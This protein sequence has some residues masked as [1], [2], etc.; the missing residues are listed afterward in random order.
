MSSAAPLLPGLEEAMSGAVTIA[1]VVKKVR[2]GRGDFLVLE[3]EVERGG[4]HVIE[5]WVGEVPPT[6]PGQPVRGTGSYQ[7]HTS[8]GRQFKL[9]LLVP[10]IPSTRAGIIE[11][12]G[13]GQIEGIGPVYARAIVAHFGDGVLDVLDTDP[14]RVQEVPGI[15]PERSA[16]IVRGWRLSQA[17]ARVM[18]YLQGHGAPPGIAA[19]V[20]RHY[21]DKGVDPMAVVSGEPYRL[22]LE[23]FGIGFDTADALARSVGV[24]TDSVERAQ[25]AALHLIADIGRN[26]HTYIDLDELTGRTATLIGRQDGRREIRVA[27]EELGARGK[28]TLDAYEGEP[29]PTLF[30]PQ[31][32]PRS[33]VFEPAVFEAEW[34]VA[35]R[36]V[37]L[38]VGLGRRRG[39]LA[40]HMEVYVER[41]C[42][43]FEQEQA[44]TLAPE[45]R[46][47]VLA[48]ATNP[49][50]VITGGPGTGKSTCTRAILRMCALA[51]LKV[52][53]AAP[54][55]RAAK[56]LAEV[57]GAQEAATIHR[58]IGM[59]R[60]RR[61][62]FNADHPLDTDV[63]LVDECSMVSTDL[64][65]SV[66]EAVADGTRVVLVGDK[67]QLPSVQPG[68]VLRDVIASGAVPV[69]RL[70][71]IY[72]QGPGSTISRAAV[73]IMRGRV[74]RSDEGSDGEFFVLLR[75]T[76]EAALET[77]EALVVDRIPRRL[78][79]E[80]TE[81]A[82]MV[83]QHK[84]PGGTLA[85]NARL[86]EVLNPKGREIRRAGRV[87]R[88]GDKVLQLKNNYD[89]HLFN[90]D[91][92][93]VAEVHRDAG[94]ITVD[95]DG[96]RVRC[97]DE[98]MD[99]ITLAYATSIHKNQGSESPA[100]VIYLGSEHRHMLARNLT[101]TAVT[102]GR[103]MVVVVASRDALALAVRE[104]RRDIRRTRL[105]ERIK[106][107]A[108]A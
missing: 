13:S 27:I 7:D 21:L 41:A 40:G 97:D 42:A 92:G 76:P 80:P 2:G 31:R 90:G 61:P 102:R 24:G 1:G 20:V 64:A 101:Y 43:S 28:L 29:E 9:D 66:L 84:G 44:V 8:Y 106:A 19:K 4:R 50:V 17:T 34:A 5:T 38:S 52:R 10:V 88:A 96:R 103:K 49:V 56:R 6:T 75:E 35:S 48:V 30:G 86:Q 108:T 74:P 55:A 78:G 99:D 91:V 54:T 104:Q 57:T 59:Q 39:D 53:L 62:E 81:I 82:V 11:Y 37:A 15:G 46:A 105:A 85:L 18:I 68:A 12:L 107:F 16:S 87:F 94:E 77:I 58:L 51:E 79:I 63:L 73:E 45:Q 32:A 33:A 83:P 93:F 60:R 14:Q 47:A 70:D 72:R 67:D 23:V 69:I 26:G 98:M 65:R 95:F 100:V 25:A 89:A 3:V 36:L 22:A 71:H